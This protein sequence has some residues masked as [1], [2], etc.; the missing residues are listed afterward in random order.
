M[1]RKSWKVFRRTLFAAKFQSLADEYILT[2]GLLRAKSSLND[3]A[4]FYFS[5]IK[6]FRVSYR[7]LISLFT[8]LNFFI[9]TH[10]YLI[11]SLFICSCLCVYLL[12]HSDLFIFTLLETYYLFLFIYLYLRL[13]VL[14]CIFI[15]VSL[16]ILIY[17]YL[18]IYSH[19][20][21]YFYILM[22]V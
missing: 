9:P 12:S 10:V 7:L 13:F 3:C 18:F 15:Y 20:F 16:Y 21:L 2:R 22:Y 6:W 11:F 4:V 19:S 17:L 14:I 5:E 8:C 1:R